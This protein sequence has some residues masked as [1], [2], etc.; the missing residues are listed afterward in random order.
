[1]S[2]ISLK[3]VSITIP[4]YTSDSF[5]VKKK[6]FGKYKTEY[7]DILKNI[8]LEVTDGERVGI[9]GHNGSGKTSFLRLLAG[10]Y[11]PTSGNCKIEGRITSLIDIGMGLDPEASGYA[12]IILKLISLGM[13]YKD[14]KLI[15]SIV[16]FSGLTDVIHHPIRTYS[17]G[18]GVRLAFSISTCITPEILLLD[19]WLSVGDADFIAKSQSRMMEL[20]KKSPIIVVA[21]HDMG[22]LK[23][24]CNKI[25]LFENGT[26]IDQIYVND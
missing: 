3:N 23:K 25:L 11:K 24:I 13:D 2:H 18:M 4:V 12:N 15:K 21:S 6:L 9:Y 10:A 17:S 19:E 5:S 20:T 8:N 22:L 1:M 14:T 7:K 16:D 26:I